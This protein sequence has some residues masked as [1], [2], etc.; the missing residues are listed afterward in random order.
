MNATLASLFQTLEANH[1][2]Y[3]VLRDYALL[4]SPNLP[5]DVDLLVDRDLL[6]RLCSTLAKQGFTQVT[7]QGY[8]PHYFFVRYLEHEDTWLKLDVVTE[9]AFGN[10]IFALQ[11]DLAVTCLENRQQFGQLY[12]LSSEN[13]IITLLLHCVLDKQAFKPSRQSQL[14]TLSAEVQESTYLTALLQKYWLTEMTWPQMKVLIEAGNW[15]ALLTQRHAVA[16][17]IAKQDQLGTLFRKASRRIL[18]KW[19]HI[20]G[21]FRPRVPSIALLAPD[22]AGKS[23]LAS[24]LQTSF[25]L[26]VHP[27]YMGLYQKTDSGHAQRRIPGIS[28]LGRLLTQWQRYFSARSHQAKGRLVIFDRYT[29]DALLSPSHQLNNLRRFRQWLLAHACPA[30]DLVVMLDAPGEILYSRKREHTPAKLEQQR[31]RYLELQSEIPQMIVIDAANSAI[32]VK[33]RVTSLI[34]DSF[35]NKLKGN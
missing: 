1:I 12:K 30:P 7:A 29:Y 31:Q 25:Y 19:N 15:P 17:H 5:G 21:L 18:R 8:E 26:P 14:Q 11:T 24:H 27:V 28:L 3:C 20:E 16:S 2:C 33:K 10:R 9:I 4:T 34:W 35:L 6:P 23:T 13:E 22:G 32:E